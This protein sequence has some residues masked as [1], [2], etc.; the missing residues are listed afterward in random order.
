[1]STTAYTN[2]SWLAIAGGVVASITALG[3]I[4]ADAIQSGHVDLYHLISV[5]LI[6][7]TILCAHISIERI[8]LGK[9][10]SG[11]AVAVPAVV[12]TALVLYS[13]IGRQAD[14]SDA[15]V[16][17]ATSIAERRA[18]LT[19]DLAEAKKTR[20]KAQWMKAWEIAG[21]PRLHGKPNM[22]GRPSGT[23]GCGSGCRGWL[24][25]ADEAQSRIEHLE[26]QLAG[27]A[28][29]TA[30]PRADRA[31]EIVT[32]LSGGDKGHVKHILYVIEPVAY[33]LAFEICAIVLF[34]VGLGLP[35]RGHGVALASA[36]PRG[37]KPFL[38][39]DDTDHP[40]IRELRTNGPAASQDELA[41][42]MGLSKGEISKT[43]DELRSMLAVE[44]HGRCHRVAVAA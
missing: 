14:V 32:M 15:Q 29:P 38:V 31:A 16:A 20:T 34:T 5:P 30:A 39:P 22:D 18:A 10:V 26:A 3:M 33:A 8:Y 35:A 13:S 40:L 44:R 42:R 17:S 1:M 41:V 2:R 24:Q 25:T 11:A 28:V 6:V 19:S 36:P 27:L 7:L 23:A 43:V 37:G 12:C 9:L 4:N 21:R